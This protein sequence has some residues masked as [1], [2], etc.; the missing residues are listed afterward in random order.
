MAF[1]EIDGFTHHVSVRGPEN[2]PALVFSN[3]LGTDFRIWDK[4][5]ALLPDS[6]RVMKYD[7]RGHGLSELTPAPYRM[8]T[9]VGDVAAL[10]DHF[11]MKDTIFV[12]LSVGGIIAQGLRAS[13]PDLVRAL[14][15]C[16]TANVIGPKEMWNTRIDAISKGGIEPL[17]DAV[18][19][20]WFSPGFRANRKAEL[21]GW[22]NML[23]R[24]PAEGYIGVSSAIRDADM[25]E[26]TREIDVPTMCV[27]GTDDGATTPA[28]VR[29]LADLIDGSRF[30]TIE[31]VGH[32]PCLEQPEVLA[33][34]IN[35]FLK[36]NDLV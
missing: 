4:V 26:T 16:D 20:R 12:G 3:S 35:D 10:M 32:L 29:G 28:M 18:M 22:R 27:V 17:G 9:L 15:L 33:G 31:G 13:R 2:G 21:L 8:E 14:V 23:V 11:G 25:T 36:E 34:L 7:K 6:F 19:E 1:V 30:E 5:I 24:T